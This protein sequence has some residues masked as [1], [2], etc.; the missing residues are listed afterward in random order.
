MAQVIV[1]GGGLAGC[2]AAHTVLERGGRVLVL[3]KMPYLGG[4]SVKATGGINAA[5]TPAQRAA[6]IQ[7]TPELFEEDTARS[8][9]DRLRPELVHTL[10]HRSAAAV[11]WLQ[12]AFDLDLTTVGW[13]AG[14][15]APRCHRTAKRFPGTEITSRLIQR[16][17]Q[18]CETTPHLARIELSSRV[19]RLLTDEAGD[20]VGVEFT[21]HQGRSTAAQG[22]VVLATG[23]FAADFGPDSL[24]LQCNATSDAWPETRPQLL[25]LPT[26]NGAHCTGDGVKIARAI[27]AGAVDMDKIQVHPTGLVFPDNPEAKT[28]FLASE[29][30]RGSGGLL[31]TADGERFV[32]ELAKRD[33]V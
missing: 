24:L 3:D 10:T 2:C 28:L 19:T 33:V 20:V 32:D 11:E 6:K 1:V 21:D 4:N 13:M 26:S 12:T 31:L 22:P 23:G 5:W 18:V 15:K 27:G 7:D 29:A 30:L 9:G 25:N 16:L 17:Q 14:A 8:A